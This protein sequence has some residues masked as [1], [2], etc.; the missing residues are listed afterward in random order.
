VIEAKPGD[1]YAALARRSSLRDH[2]EETLRL[3]N[4]DYPHG[5]PHAGDPVK[6]VQ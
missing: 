6:I 1:T 5:E 2:A 3:L 4:G